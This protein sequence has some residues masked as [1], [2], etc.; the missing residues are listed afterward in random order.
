MS[1]VGDVNVRQILS[2]RYEKCMIRGK[3][4]PDFSRCF[5]LFTTPADPWY[6]PID[7]LI[8]IKGFVEDDR[9][10]KRCLAV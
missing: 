6:P 1:P 10:R 7:R 2:T 4:L 9:V 8:D 5:M 3:S